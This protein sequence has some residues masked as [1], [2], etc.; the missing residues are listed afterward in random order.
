[1]GKE[2]GV[3]VRGGGAGGKT[4]RKML[5]EIQQDLLTRYYLNV[6]LTQL[7]QKNGYDFNEGLFCVM[8]ML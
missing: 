7:F 6:L 1:M 8:L 4:Q 2:V 5:Q 3:C